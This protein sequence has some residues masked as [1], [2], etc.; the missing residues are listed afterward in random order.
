MGTKAPFVV[1]GGIVRNRDWVLED[2]IQSLRANNVNAL[3]YLTGDN[4]DNTRKILLDNGI[5]HTCWDTGH[6]G[7]RRGEYTSKIMGMLRNQWVEDALYVYPEAT[8]L[9]SVD[10]DVIVPSNA[11][12][13]LLS[14]DKDVMAAYV[15]VAGGAIP[16][17][18]YGWSDVEGHPVR[19]GDERHISSQIRRCTLVGACVLMKTSM[20]KKCMP[21]YG[22]DGQGEDGYAARIFRNNGI[23]QWVDPIVICEHRME[24]P[25]EWKK[26][27][28]VD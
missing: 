19:T 18:M 11:L 12:D 7:W 28:G 3:Y 15:P 8:H 10:S 23:E 21:V 24:I 2:S 25:T 27:Y 14:H 17:H 6:P 4:I 16:I 13:A 22:A 9:W 20:L 1:A 26:R 5:K